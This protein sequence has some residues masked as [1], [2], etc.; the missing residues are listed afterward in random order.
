MTRERTTENIV[1]PDQG[2]SVLTVLASTDYVAASCIDTD[3]PGYLVL[4]S[5]A[6]PRHLY[7]GSLKSQMEIGVMLARL[8]SAILKVTKAEH[9]YIARF[10]EAVQ[11]MHFHLFPRTPAIAA[12]FLLENPDAQYGV[13]GPLLFDWARRKYHV[14]APNELSA[15]TISAAKEIRTA[16]RSW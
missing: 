6:A 2:P 16:L 11:F 12:E 15:T 1:P 13:N 8:E 10:S 3:F 4:R 5:I 7:E 14:N 9:V